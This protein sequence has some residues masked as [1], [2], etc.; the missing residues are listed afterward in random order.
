M[1]GQCV[2]SRVRD[3]SDDINCVYTVSRYKYFELWI[4]IEAKST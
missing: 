2:G 1:V 4:N 3:D